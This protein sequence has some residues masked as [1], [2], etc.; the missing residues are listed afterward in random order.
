VYIDP[1]DLPT[2]AVYFGMTPKTMSVGGVLPSGSVNSTRQ[3]KTPL[4]APAVPTLSRRVTLTAG[5]AAAPITRA[6]TQATHAEYNT[7]RCVFCGSVRAH[8]GYG[9]PLTPTPFWVCRTHRAEAET[10]ILNGAQP[11]PLKLPNDD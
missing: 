2:I 3:T 7:R 10:A 6:A 5:T 8:F 9:P 4:A 11:L 1:V